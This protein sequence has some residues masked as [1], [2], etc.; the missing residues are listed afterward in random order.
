M[1]LTK[2]AKIL[3]KSQSRAAVEFL[4]TTRNPERDTVIFLLSVKAGCR[5]K[6]IAE[7]SW[8]MVTDS[9]GN[10]ADSMQL[11]NTASKGRNGGR[12]IPLN[13]VLKAALVD[14][15]ELAEVSRAE[16]GFPFDLT[17][18]VVAS[19]RGSKMS[20]NSIAHWFKRLF[21]SLGFDA[22][23]HS[24]RRTAITTWARGISR[25]GGSLRDVQALAGH[26]SLQMTQ[27]YIVENGDAKR[28]LV[29]LV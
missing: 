7:I 21:S 9:E 26:S 29:D 13:S 15:K 2:Q 19:E 12:T 22:S 25:V 3:S 10:I 28:K 14:L 17:S 24:G 6:E 27:L 1:G 11:Q 8:K 18:N 16:A 5:A 4:K 20:A 23:S